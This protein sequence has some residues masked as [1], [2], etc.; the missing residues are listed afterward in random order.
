MSLFKF[1]ESHEEEDTIA[2]HALQAGQ[3]FL[4]I[5]H[6]TIGK[7]TVWVVVGAAEFYDNPPHVVVA[8]END[9]RVVKTLSESALLNSKFYRQ[10]S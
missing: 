6:Q 2:K 1:A 8:Q 3:R 10:L 7:A 5:S 4:K 9:M